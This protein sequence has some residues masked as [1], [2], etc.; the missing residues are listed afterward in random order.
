MVLLGTRTER[1][2]KGAWLEWLLY[3]YNDEH[4]NWVYSVYKYIKR[5]ERIVYCSIQLLP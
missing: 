5:M 1:M 2:G 3:K 4:G